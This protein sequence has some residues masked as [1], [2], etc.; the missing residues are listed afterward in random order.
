MNDPQTKPPSPPTARAT[1]AMALVHAA[2]GGLFLYVVLVLAPRQVAAFRDFNMKL[3]AATGFVL[4]LANWL[5]SWTYL[6]PA[7]VVLL[8]AA[9]TIL[10]AAF[11]HRLEARMLARVWFG[12]VTFGMCI[13][14]GALLVALW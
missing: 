10:L 5:A 9:D 7:A 12:L 8:L 13:A 14:C 2:L 4:A 11:R 1:V 6:V 3:P